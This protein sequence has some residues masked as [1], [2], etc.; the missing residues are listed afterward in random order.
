MDA[1]T[2]IA[3]FTDGATLLGGHIG[4]AHC[5][6]GNRLDCPDDFI[7]RTVGRLGLLGGGFGVL[8]LGAHALHR[9]V[10]CGLQAGNQPLNLCGGAGGALGQ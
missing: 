5:R 2:V 8:D 10:G 6:V 3:N 9:L 7:Q 4:D 1:F